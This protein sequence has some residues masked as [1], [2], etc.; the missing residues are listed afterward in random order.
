MPAPSS[1]TTPGAT[2]AL[3]RMLE[4]KPGLASFT[5]ASYDAELHGDLAGARVGARAG[6]R[7][8]R[9]AAGEAF[10]RTY[11]GALAFSTGDLDEA[12]RST[13]P[14][15]RGGAGR[16]GAAARPGPR[17]RG[18]R[19]RATAAVEA[20]R[21]VVDASRCRSTSS[22]SASTWSRMGRDDEAD[23]AVRARGDGARGSSRR[24]G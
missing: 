19:G 5:R 3:Q 8:D 4:L 9:R 1:A 14:G 18:A 20:F 24:A 15:L 21:A 17:A 2:A 22:S 13:P 11:L 6:A 10:C 12:A 7:D 16:S 23:A